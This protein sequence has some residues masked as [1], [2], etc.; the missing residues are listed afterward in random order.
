FKLFMFIR[1]KNEEYLEFLMVLRQ[2]LQNINTSDAFGL[3]LAPEGYQGSNSKDYLKVSTYA[4]GYPKQRY[5]GVHFYEDSYNLSLKR[6]K[7]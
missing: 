3:T 1:F 4:I 5:E 2:P 6:E 7:F